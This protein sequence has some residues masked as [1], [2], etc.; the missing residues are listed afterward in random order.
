MTHTDYTK[1]IL[2]IEDDNIYFYDDC[3]EIKN[4][5]GIQTK[6]FHGYLTYT[7]EFCPICGCLN[8]NTNDIIK[9]N[10]KRNCNIKMTKVSNYN[11]ILLLDKQRF[12]CKHCN[13]TFTASTNVVDFHNQ[14]SNDTKLS[15]RLELMNKISEKDIA[16]HFN[17]SHNTVNRIMDQ[18]SRR[19][20]LPGS[21]PTIMNFDEFKATNNTLGKMAFIITDSL[22]HKTFDILESRKSN[23]LKKYFFRFPRK[24][25]LAVKFIIIDLFEPYYHLFKS[26]FPNAIIISDRFHIVAQASNALKCTRIQIMK[27]DK[28]NYKKLKYYWK[29]LQKCELDLNH[30]KKYSNHFKKSM[31]EYDIVQYLIHTNQM[32]KNTYEIYQGIIKAIRNRDSNLFI[33][34]IESKHNNVSEYMKKTLKTYRKF[35]SFI[36]HSLNYDYNN[37]LIEGINNLIKCIKRI[38]FGYRSF[39]HFK[40]RILLVTGVYTLSH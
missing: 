2:N 8:H 7:P 33:H 37:G 9:W 10:W 12:F 19:P 16:K 31:T 25:R 34:I 17:V 28:K 21:L 30:K 29:L 6:I 18:L 22:H 11:T 38:A 35:K 15:I 36:I 5:N 39:Y 32:L 24:Q 3:L 23:Y 26:I 13:R 1:N 14:I 20:I 40:T 27:N 4:I